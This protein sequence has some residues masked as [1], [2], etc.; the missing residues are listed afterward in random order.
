MSFL[1]GVEVEGRGEG[2]GGQIGGGFVV[3]REVWEVGEDF[4]VTGVF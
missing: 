1:Q 2:V 3:P 4:G